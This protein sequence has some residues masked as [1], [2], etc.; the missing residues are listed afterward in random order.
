MA[1]VTAGRAPINC[2][3]GSAAGC[4]VLCPLGTWTAFRMRWT[5]RVSQG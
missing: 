4:G 3:P 2:R 5:F 1:A